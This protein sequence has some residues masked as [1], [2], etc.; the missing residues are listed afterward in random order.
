MICTYR[1]NDT[2]GYPC[3][4]GEVFTNMKAY[5][6]NW[7]S[8]NYIATYCYH[9]RLCNYLQGKTIPKATCLTRLRVIFTQTQTWTCFVHLKITN[10]V[11]KNNISLAKQIVWETQIWHQYFSNPSFSSYWSKISYNSYNKYLITQEP[12]GLVK[13]NVIVGFLSLFQDAY[14]II[15]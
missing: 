14:A 8:I 2:S 4:L 13:F 10:T 11:F 9:W 3:C 7:N 1:F 5:Q 15:F 6:G 12:R